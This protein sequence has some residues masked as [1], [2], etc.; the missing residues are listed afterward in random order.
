[1]TNKNDKSADDVNIGKQK[2]QASPP[3]NR[4]K[5]RLFTTLSKI[6]KDKNKLTPDQPKKN[7]KSKR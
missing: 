6:N 7:K 2:D 4:P 1:M 5:G 3:A